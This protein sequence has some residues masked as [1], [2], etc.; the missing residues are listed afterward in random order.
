VSDQGDC[1]KLYVIGDVTVDH[2]YF[3]SKLPGP[4]E[5]VS[6]TR[7]TLIPGGAGGTI[8][9][10]LAR[11]GHEV[12]LAARV[13]DDPF[14]ALAL[15]HLREANVNLTQVQQDRNAMTSTITIMVTPDAERAMISSGGANRNLDA[16]E[17][18]KKDI[19]S[20]DG[21]V[22]SAYSL[23]GGAQREFA[24]KAIDTA[25][26]AD[27][28][29]FI[30]LGTGAVNAAG[31]KLLES[32]KGAD[33]LLMNQLE[34][35]RITEA[36]SISDALEGLHQRGV[37]NVVIKVGAMGSIVWTPTETELLEGYEI[38]GV[39]D[40]TGAGDA[41]TAAFASAV[42]S[43]LDMKRAARY[44]NV[45]GAM[46]ATNVGAQS[47]PLSHQTILEH[48]GGERSKD[49]PSETKPAPKP[50]RKTV[51]RA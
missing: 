49:Q 29:V 23:I 28:P 30:D 26:K 35:L 41:F 5:D 50:A 27:V 38:D 24:V 12:T 44:A 6:P 7:S 51:S 22:V 4:G 2:L 1:V 46:V 11:L 32:V 45:A 17:L 19:E 43:G 14:Q 42:L 40:S 8:A 13:G 33:Y 25:K 3:L 16:A 34:L 15:R 18:K 31:A 20:A 10:Y 48:L 36:S 39:V 9:Y 37:N 21:L 47:T